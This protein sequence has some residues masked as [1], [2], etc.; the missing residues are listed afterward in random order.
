MDFSKTWAYSDSW[1]EQSERGGETKIQIF[2]KVLFL[3]EKEISELS[4]S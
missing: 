1:E 4:P 2:E 3:E